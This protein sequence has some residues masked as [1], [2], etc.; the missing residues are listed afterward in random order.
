MH[1]KP[2]GTSHWTKQHFKIDSGAYGN[3]MPLS[4]YKSLYNPV[5]SSTTVNSAVCLLDYNKCEIKQL[6]TCVVS[7]KYR[8]NV[9]WVPF[10]IVSDKLKPIIGV[11]DALSL[12][13]TFFH[14][15]ICIDW[16]SNL[17]NSVDSIHSNAGSTLHTGTGTGTGMGIVNLSTQEFTMDTLTKQAIVSHS[18]YVS[19]FSEIGHFRCSPVHITMRQN[20][21]SVQKPPRRVPI[22]MKDKFKQELD[23]MGS[24]GIISKYDGHDISP[25]WLNSCVIV[26]KPNCSLRICLDPTNLNKDI[27]RPVCNS[28]TMDDV[29]HRLQGAKFFTVFNTS[30]GFFHIPLGQESKLLTVMLTPFGIYVYNI[31][32]MG[33]SNATDLFETC[34][35]EVLQGSN[36]CTN[37]T[38]DIL[39]YGSTYDEFK[40]NVLAFLDPCVQEDMHLNPGKVKLDCHEVSFFG[41]TLSK[42][43]LSPDNRKVELIQQWPTPTNYKELQ[44]FLGTINYLSIF[45]A[46]LSDVCAPL[47]TLLKKGTEFIWTLVHQHA[48]DQIKLRVSNDVK[49]QFYNANKPLYIQMDMSNKGIGVVMLQEDSIVWNESKSEIPTNLIPILYAG[50]TLSTTESNYSNIEHEL[51]GLLFAVTHFKHFTYG[52][53]VHIITDHKPLVPLFRKSLV[54]SSPW[55]TRMLVQLLDFTLDVTYQPGAQMHLSDTLSRL[56]THDKNEDE[57]IANSDVSIHATEE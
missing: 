21:T 2:I 51:L 25:E 55:L 18:K 34:I 20:A 50:K 43:A 38:D 53:P 19:L 52:R 39:V 40:N 41:N 30:K 26:K 22:A 14:H 7:A 13:L 56:S 37:I 48:F 46:F 42:D 1:V 32:A 11:S 24:Q 9:K 47:Q 3:L 10:Y 31:L 54:D 5:P 12:G 28:Q 16:Q 15:P 45:L 44:S 6:G 36:V 29:V 8:S 33:L 49:L 23:A 27:I 35:C 17:T 57:T 4:M